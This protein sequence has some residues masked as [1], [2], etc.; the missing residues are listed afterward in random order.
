V[1]H[2][3]NVSSAVASWH[4]PDVV[5]GALIA[6]SASAVTAWFTT[7]NSRQ[8]VD[9]QLKDAALQRE[10]ERTMTLRRAVYLPAVE[11]LTR[12]VRAI[13]TAIDP[14]PAGASD[15]Q[16]DVA[17]AIVALGSLELIA[18]EE[19]VRAVLKYK[20]V[21]A[22]NHAEV[23][24]LRAPIALLNSQRETL[25]NQ[26]AQA[27][28]V[29]E[30]TAE[31]IKE[32]AVTGADAT[33][34]MRLNDRLTF[35]QGRADDYAKQ[36]RDLTAVMAADAIRLSERATA[37]GLE[38]AAL[39]PDTILA[40]RREL[41]LPIDEGAYHDLYEEHHAWARTQLAESIARMRAGLSSWLPEIKKEAS[42]GTS[43]SD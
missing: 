26:C 34:V 7:R 15:T 33:K 19:V 25:H 32:L 30:R 37:L 2:V 1:D 9:M 24:F 21:L 3:W 16:E 20:A 35:E 29:T 6:A 28:A 17:A 39:A 23:G 13:S 22:R 5:W 43:A 8:V 40:I 31:Q 14:R 18:G 11:A 42:P 38:L 12:G 27:I 36:L 10:R 4:V 41:E